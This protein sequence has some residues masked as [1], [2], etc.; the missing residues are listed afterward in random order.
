MSALRDI[1]VHGLA[2]IRLIDA[3]DEDAAAVRRQLGLPFTTLASEPDLVLRFVDRLELESPLRYLGLDDAAFAG[4]SFL[5]LRGRRKSRAR[6]QIPMDR[7]GKRC[8]VTCERGLAAVPLLVPI[9]NLTLLAKGVLPLHAAAFTHE[10]AGWLATGWSKGGKTETL[11]SFMAEGAAFV[12]D[13]WTYVTADGRRMYGIPEPIRLWSWHLAAMPRHRRR[14]P[15]SDRVRLR[16]L[17]LGAAGIERVAGD[18]GNLRRL[19]HLIR[20]RLHVDVAPARLF[21]AEACSLEGTPDRILFVVSTD[22]P[23]VAIRPVDPQEVAER[24]MPSL[25][26]EQL[27][28]ASYY[29]KFRFAFPHRRNELVESS[30][31]LQRRLLRQCFEGKEAYELSHPYPVEIP[32]LFAAVAE[33]CRGGNRR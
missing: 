19:R 13:E 4:D 6:A 1:D 7:I 31:E 3:G 17:E 18:A 29:W 26:H 15:R 20:S 11:L 8:E 16:A 28:F 12:G 30:H 32:A 33:R 10:G 25:Q 24:V 21:G 5:V 22:S 23:G 9:L 14:V 2:G 27:H